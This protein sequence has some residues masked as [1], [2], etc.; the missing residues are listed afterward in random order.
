MAGDIPVSGWEPQDWSKGKRVAGLEALRKSVDG[1]VVGALQWYYDRKWAKKW[2]SLLTRGFSIAFTAVGSLLPLLV[3]T[4][5]LDCG[6]DGAALLGWHAKV[7][8]IGYIAIGLAAVCVVIDR[9]L[10]SSTGWM[11]YMAAANALETRR[12]SFHLAWN[13]LDIAL[14][15]AEPDLRQTV[16]RVELLEAFAADARKVVADETSAWMAEF[17]ASLAEMEKQAQAA[18]EQAAKGAEAAGVAADARNSAKLPGNLQITVGAAVTTGFEVFVG[19][20]S[21]GKAAT[22]GVAGVAAGFQ[23]VG[24]RDADGTVLA[25]KVVDVKPSVIT[26]VSFP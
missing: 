17:Q 22:I 21:V 16:E 18:R 25:S 9:F 12:H 2:T 11:R 3:S 14:E 8:G 24:L 5:W 7:N 19:K 10:G 20:A 6:R 1:N 4:G 23:E 15:G 26:A 13:R